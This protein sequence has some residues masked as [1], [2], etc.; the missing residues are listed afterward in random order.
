VSS[1]WAFG[2]GRSGSSGAGGHIFGAIDGSG[3]SLGICILNQEWRDVVMYD[4]GYHVVQFVELFFTL[5]SVR[6]GKNVAIFM[7]LF[8]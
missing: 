7:H 6:R 8:L 4:R 5:P 2:L 3:Q 1:A